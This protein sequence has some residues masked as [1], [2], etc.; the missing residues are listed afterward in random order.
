MHETAHSRITEDK[1][2]TWQLDSFMVQAFGENGFTITVGSKLAFS[3][4]RRNAI[5]VSWTP[6]S[7]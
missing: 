3:C 6:L 7:E 2:R 4:P 1:V 5:T